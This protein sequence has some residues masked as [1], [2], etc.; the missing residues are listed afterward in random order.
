MSADTWSGLALRNIGPALTE[1]RIVD[2]AVDPHDS[3]RYFVAAA[4]GGVWRTTNAGVTFEPV[5]DGE[6]SYSIG[7]ITIDP[8]NSNVIWVG[9]GE[10]N[11][12]RSVGY[13]DGVYKSEDGG[14]SWS[15][16]GLKDSEHIGRIVVDPRDSNV[17]YVAAQ[18]P[19][20]RSGGDRGVYKTTDGGKTWKPALTVDAETGAN[21]VIMDPRNP[22]LLY[23]STYQRR[24]HVWT[25]IDGGPGSAVYRSSDAGATW[26]KLE[27][28]LPKE[29]KGKI[30]IALAPTAPDTLYAIVESTPKNG[31]FY[32]STDRGAN[33]SKMSKEGSSSPQYYNELFVD[34]VNKDR[35]Y[36]MD[37]FL[38]VTNDGGKTFA[39]LGEK[40][41]H[42]DN[43]V[44]WIDPQNNAHYRVG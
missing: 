12:Q 37:T 35:V 32:R 19:L 44:I 28:G 17:V 5:F 33:W 15:N 18:G 9:S 8:N 31:G 4:A 20:W 43:H 27:N 1:G 39:R 7:C 30:G 22:D 38:R 36:S 3:S 25:L 2:L 6:E 26:T 24:R 10:N 23:A 29:D 34:P 41:K 21:E 14:S 11:S 42:V 13:G 40:S 16:V